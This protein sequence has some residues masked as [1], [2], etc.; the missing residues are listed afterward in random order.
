MA[1]V[2]SVV[3]SASD[4]HDEEAEIREVNPILSGGKCNSQYC[5]YQIRKCLTEE[6]YV[7]IGTFFAEEEVKEPGHSGFCR[8]DCE[9]GYLC[10]GGKCVHFG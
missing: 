3:Q 4:Y 9:F 8:P 5:F 7:F 2:T 6:C 10:R 1:S